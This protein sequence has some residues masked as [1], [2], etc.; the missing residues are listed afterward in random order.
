MKS[1]RTTFTIVSTALLAAMTCVSTMIIQIPTPTGGYIH[2]GD[3]FV[4]LSGILLGPIY[5]GLAAGIGSMFADL[6]SG[7]PQYAIATLLIKGIAAIVGG[8]I[9]S[10]L[11]RKKI[12]RPIAVIAAGIGGGII[13]TSGYFSFDSFLLGSGVVAALTGIPTNTIQNIFG[14]IV[15]SLLLPFLEKTPVLQNLPIY[16]KDSID[17]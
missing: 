11:S 10:T 4:L 3:G 6:L 17:N 8:F 12:S 7:Y 16:S 1:K 15:S 13:V 5:G 9:Y 14:I 2:L